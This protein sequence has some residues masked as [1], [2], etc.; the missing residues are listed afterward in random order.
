MHSTPPLCRI[1]LEEVSGKQSA[2]EAAL[3]KVKGD[4]AA[5]ST[6]LE[7]IGT[8]CAQLLQ[9]GAAGMGRLLGLLGLGVLLRRRC[10][11]AYPLH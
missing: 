8:T 9:A 2:L 1:K 7:G 3:D 10:T 5:H 6:A 11:L 4:L